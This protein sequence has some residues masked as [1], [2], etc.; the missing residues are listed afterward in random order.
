VAN[1]Y[2]AQSAFDKA[3]PFLLR[4]VQ[5][6]SPFIEE[7]KSG[8]DSL[9]LWSLCDLYDKWNKP[10]KAEPRYRQA[11][12]ILEKKYG[13][14]NPALLSTLANEARAL[15]QLGRATDAAKVEQ[16]LESIRAGAGQTEGAVLAPQ[17]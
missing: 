12:S 17:Q 3:E 13:A 6:D 7:D 4:A 10:E 11:L 15:H 9:P 14:D 5:I 1:A 16:R 8:M 2:I